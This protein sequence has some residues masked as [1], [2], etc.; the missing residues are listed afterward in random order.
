[1]NR[2]EE[3]QNSRV[4]TPSIIW[5]LRGGGKPVD[6]EKH[7]LYSCNQK[8]NKKA[9][10]WTQKDRVEREWVGARRS[11]VNVQITLSVSTF[12]FYPPLTT[13]KYI[14]RM[15]LSDYFFIFAWL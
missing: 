1:M 12:K 5:T 10:K 7:M 14:I 13:N 9:C 6:V 11:N 8:T 2:L 4:E 15:L 3:G